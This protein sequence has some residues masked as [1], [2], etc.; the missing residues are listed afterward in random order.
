MSDFVYFGDKCS[1][2][3]FMMFWF[4]QNG[5]K[6]QLVHRRLSFLQKWQTPLFRHFLNAVVFFFF[7][8]ERLLKFVCC[9]TRPRT[10]DD[11]RAYFVLVQVSSCFSFIYT[12][13]TV[14]F[15]THNLLFLFVSP[16]IIYPSDYSYKQ[17][18]PPPPLPQP[19]APHFSS[20]P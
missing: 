6:H 2:L 3:I 15:R 16:I 8:V 12:K 13:P 20:S 9:L 18:S 4:K 7:F 14:V 5:R 10:K 1:F 11:L 19:P 17:R